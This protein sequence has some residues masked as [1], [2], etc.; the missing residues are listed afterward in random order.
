MWLCCICIPYFLLIKLALNLYRW[1]HVD[2]AY[3]T[4]AFSL[5]VGREIGLFSLSQSNHTYATRSTARQS[6]VT[7]EK[8]QPAVK[9]GGA[10]FVDVTLKVVIKASPGTLFVFKPEQ[11]HGTTLAH[12]A[13][14]HNIA[15][16]FSQQLED[17]Y[18]EVHQ[19]GQA[20]YSGDG[21]GE[22]NPANYCSS[23]G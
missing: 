5:C 4:W 18:R 16:T 23:Q 17:G 13:V 14:N 12:G 8:S 9:G 15:I 3:C 20:V 10:N 21:A 6:S 19:K 7:K 11:L 2:P 22:G 1:S